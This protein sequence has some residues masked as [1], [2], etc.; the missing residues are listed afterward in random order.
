MT[1]RAARS[2]SSPAGGT[3]GS[4]SFD[5]PGVFVELPLVNRMRPRVKA[6][7]EARYPGVTGTTLRLLQHWRDPETW[8]ERRFFFCQLEAVETLIWLTEAPAGERQGIEVPGDGGPF[9]RLCAKMATGSGK[10]LVMAM[11]IAWHILNRVANPQDARFSKHVFVLAPGLTVKKRLAV[12]EPSDPGNYYDA[13]NMVPSAL[14]ERLRQGRVLV[15]NWHV[16]NWESDEQIARKRGVDKRGARSDAVY[17]R[18]VLGD[19]ASA[20][21]LLV[22]NDEAHH[23]WRLPAESKIR[24][25][26]KADIE[27]ATRWIGGL[28][29]IQ[30]SRGIIG[31]YDFSATP[32]APSGKESTEEALF[33][34]IVS[35]FSLNDAIESGLVKTPRVVVRDDGVPEAASFRSNPQHEPDCPAPVGSD[36]PREHPGAHAGVRQREADPQHGRHAALVYRPPLGRHRAL[37]RQPVRFRQHVG[38]E[39]GVRPRPSPRRG[40]MGE[41]RPPRVRD[42]L[43]VRRGRAQVPARL[44][45]AAHERDHARPGG[46][47]PGLAAAPGE[48]SRPGRVGAGGDGARGLRSVD[49]G[50]VESPVRSRGHGP[51]SGPV[52][53]AVTR[54]GSASSPNDDEGGEQMAKSNSMRKGKNALPQNP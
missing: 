48:A 19:M 26:A 23:A 41:E 24:G 40:R 42:R 28:D 51:G 17:I 9:A 20:S 36:P 34:W 33:G 49:V 16:L 13:F 32:F 8:E 30:R 10:T 52:S 39:R 5:D 38:S 27:E 43:R 45:R 29:R 35:D 14:R 54:L 37:A 4:K 53:P 15:R 21:N 12:L 1:A 22:V 25:V 50:G 46:Q 6:W 31:C 7:R 44:P 18:E 11:V 2:A 47:G 3:P